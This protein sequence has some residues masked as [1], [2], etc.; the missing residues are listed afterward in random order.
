MGSI[1]NCYSPSSLL[2]ADIRSLP[3]A[4]N[5]IYIF[6]FQLRLRIVLLLWLTYDINIKL[7]PNQNLSGTEGG[8]VFGERAQLIGILIRPLRQKISGAEI[9]VTS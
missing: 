9:Q 8:P 4:N 3:G 7:T 2:M 1:A 6:F 5:S